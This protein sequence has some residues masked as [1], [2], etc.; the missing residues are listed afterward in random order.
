M[1]QKCRGKRISDKLV[2]NKMTIDMTFAEDKFGK[3]FSED[4]LSDSS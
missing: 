3:I 2:I 4:V 1:T